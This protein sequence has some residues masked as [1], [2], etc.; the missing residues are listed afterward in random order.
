MAGTMSHR[1]ALRSACCEGW[2]EPSAL[3]MSLLSM[4]NTLMH[5]A[6]WIVLRHLLSRRAVCAF[7]A[8]PRAWRR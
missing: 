2:N 4:M 6:F 5:F 1:K 7:V 8:D 3:S